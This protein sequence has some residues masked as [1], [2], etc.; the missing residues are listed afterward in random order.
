MHSRRIGDV[1]SRSPPAKRR[2]HRQTGYRPDCN[3]SHRADETVNDRSPRSLRRLNPNEP[4]RY[5]RAFADGR[6]NSF[7]KRDYSRRFD[8]DKDDPVSSRAPPIG[9]PWDR[10]QFDENFPQRGPSSIEYRQKYLMPDPTNLNG[11]TN[12]SLKHVGDSENTISRIRNEKEF[13]GIS[14]SSLDGHGMLIQKPVYFNDGTVRTFFSLPPDSGSTL[15]SSKTSGN[16][17][18]SSSRNPSIGLRK[19]EEICY[20]DKIHPHKIPTRETYEEEPM[21]GGLRKDEEIRYKDQM[22][23]NKT[24]ETYEEEQMFGGLRKDEELCYRE[25]I[26]LKKI[27]TRESY[28]EVKPMFYTRDVSYPVG[29]I[30]QS[31]TFGS[32]SSGLVKDNVGSRLP[33]EGFGKGSGNFMNPY[34]RD[35]NSSAPHFDS[36]RDLKDPIYYHRDPRSPLR[37]EHQD[38]NYPEL[39]RRKN[40]ASGYEADELYRKMPLTTQGDYVNRE[41]SRPS[42]MDPDFE[43]SRR[44]M[45]ESGLL[46]PY[47]VQGEPVSSY[48]DRKRAPVVTEQDGEFLGS[49][50]NHL[51]FETRICNDRKV[52]RLGSDYV[53]DSFERD[54][55]PRS[56]R[57]RLRNGAIPQFES[58][59]YRL[60]L[61]P[62]RRLKAEELGNYD[63][64]E[65]I[66]KRKYIMD[67]E[68]SSHNPSSTLSSGRNISRRMQEPIGSNTQW[69]GRNPGGLSL[70]KRL[71]FGRQPYRKGGRPYEGMATRRASAS[72]DRFPFRDRLVHAQQCTGG[73]I[74]IKRRLRPGPLTSHNSYRLD[75]RKDSHKLKKFRKRTLDNQRDSPNVC[76]GDAVEDLVAPAKS[77][78]PEDSE[79]FKHLVH[80]AFL[81]F[82]KQLNEN[83]AQR[84]RYLEEGKAGTLLCSVCGSLSKEFV[85][86]RSLVKHTF[87]SLKVGLRADHLG[88][89]K[90]LCVLMGWRSA[91]VP[92]D[93]WVQRVLPD[94]E[95]L[96]LKEDLIL[97]PPLV[98]I[99]NTSILNANP[100]ERKVVTVEEMD[101][102][103]REMGFGSEKTKVCRGKPA[104]QSIMVVKFKPTFSGLQEAERLHNYYTEKKRGREEF[105][106]INSRSGDKSEEAVGQATN[107]VDHVLFGY[108]G[109][110]DDLDKL[111]F[112]T[113]SKCIVK[114]KKDIQAIADAPLKTD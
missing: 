94:A 93:A 16:F 25:Q 52:T 1:R 82:S 37:G 56:Y 106:Q 24:R 100:D 11:D 36:A 91:V 29:P 2:D 19:D 76:N 61:S 3:Q 103:L 67:E 22:H 54:A 60:S 84:R 10:S 46:D 30:S 62:Q 86:T 59:L 97:W 99:H 26:H 9:Q 96:S 51:E 73:N 42:Y 47:S 69:S 71:N 15:N 18:S 57:D 6:S 63:S 78:V 32:T 41:F 27:S 64:S 38:Y 7:E 44:S 40:P 89:H 77:D 4:E 75:I 39:G 112:G 95:A 102:I 21:F 20:S 109:I 113:K 87:T 28:E 45:R 23:R 35:G 14:S 107:N 85:D 8:G 17:L 74:S 88:L 79:E 58:D 48:L 70:S 53:Y 34:S 33:L 98:I 49:Q 43:R 83:P 108:M 105:L 55:A 111:D 50:S 31:K 90:A 66:L 65:R 92:D 114:S 81:R 104:N 68:M 72:D 12:P 13:Q 101:A 110:A 5:R 80:R